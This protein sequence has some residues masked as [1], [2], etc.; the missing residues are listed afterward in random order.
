MT[1]IKKGLVI[2]STGSF[3]RVK[4]EQSIID[5]KIR[6]KFREIG[7]RST[8]PVAVGDFVW[9]DYDEKNKLG[10]IKDIEDRK[11]L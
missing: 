6:G 1:N 7:F 5:C 11:N 4:T 10:I 2:K 3:Y 8:N 9:Y